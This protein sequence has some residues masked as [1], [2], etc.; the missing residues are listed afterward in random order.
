MS[1]E[2]STIEVV[3]VQDVETQSDLVKLDDLSLA[4]IGGGEL[5]VAL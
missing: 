4:M 3:E 2:Q 5:V 1:K